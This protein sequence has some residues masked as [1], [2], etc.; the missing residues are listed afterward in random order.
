MS[1]NLILVTGSSGL[2]GSAICRTLHQNFR[3][4]G[5]DKEGAPYP[6]E[7]AEWVFVDLSSDESVM[8][9]LHVASDCYGSRISA[10]C[11]LA[12][13]YDFSGRPSDLYEKV[14]IR[15]T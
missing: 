11:H 4:I 13:Y 15:G 8:N 12:A 7:T 2:I 10:V 1:Q 5:L 14:T 3:V 9:A 6:P